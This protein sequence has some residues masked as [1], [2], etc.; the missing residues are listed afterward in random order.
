MAKGYLI[1]ELNCHLPFVKSSR[2]GEYPEENWLNDAISNT[3]LPLLRTMRR[4]DTKSVPFKL[5]FTISP[6]LASMLADTI[7]QERFVSYLDS[8]IALGEKE[9]ERTASEPDK[10]KLAKMYLETLLQ[11]VTGNARPQHVVIEGSA[12]SPSLS[13]VDQQ[14]RVLCSWHD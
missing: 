3:Y 8:R 9:V 1:F 4:L 14:F 12:A 11:L 7:L 6:T 5:T 2:P 13:P 10:N